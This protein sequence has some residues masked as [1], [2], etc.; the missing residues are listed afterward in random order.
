MPNSRSVPEISRQLR[1]LLETENASIKKSSSLSMLPYGREMMHSPMDDSQRMLNSSNTC[2]TMS[3]GPYQANAPD[4][5]PHGANCANVADVQGVY[6]MPRM[7]VRS[8]E[9]NTDERNQFNL[10][11]YA[12]PRQ[13]VPNHHSMHQLNCSDCFELTQAQLGNRSSEAPNASPHLPVRVA[14]PPIEGRGRNQLLPRYWPRITDQELQQITAREY[15]LSACIQAFS[16][17]CGS[18][19]LCFSFLV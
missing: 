5:D 8:L 9:L 7:F 14:R 2:L 16:R 6:S 10:S 12:N 3:L 13:L 11:G 15:P 4:M 19:C 17:I 18:I 1:P